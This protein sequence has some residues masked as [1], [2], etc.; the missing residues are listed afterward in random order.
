MQ[1]HTAT[2]G[3]GRCQ[4]LRSRC[5]LQNI[6]DDLTTISNRRARP[7]SAAARRDHHRL[8]RS[9]QDRRGFGIY[10]NIQPRLGR[11][12]FKAGKNIARNLIGDDNA[13][14]RH[15]IAGRHIADIGEQ[16]GR[17]NIAIG[18]R[19]DCG[20]QQ[21]RLGQRAKIKASAGQRHIFIDRTG[22]N[23][24]QARIDID[25]I[26]IADVLGARFGGKAIG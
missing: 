25:H 9:Q 10:H 18:A 12:I 3:N 7:P 11:N 6:A 20:V 19:P 16:R 5:V 17:I 14:H 2:S 13:A 1:Q 15:R 22:T 21:I 23:R 4:N 8:E 26:A 24:A